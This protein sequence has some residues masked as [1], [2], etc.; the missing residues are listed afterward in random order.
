MN[1]ETLQLLKGSGYDTSKIPQQLSP[2]QP[3]QQE[4]SQGLRSFDDPAFVDELVSA[5]SPE[6]AEERWKKH[7]GADEVFASVDREILAMKAANP[8]L[9]GN[10]FTSIAESRKAELRAQAPGLGA[11]EQAKQKLNTRMEA[12]KGT[13]SKFN[14]EQWAH[15]ADL[16][17]KGVPPFEA[18][19]ETVSKVPFT[20]GESADPLKGYIGGG[21][22]GGSGG[23]NSAQSD[24]NNADSYIYDAA[25]MEAIK[26]KFD[27]TPELLLNYTRLLAEDYSAGSSIPTNIDTPE[28]QAMADEA[29]GKVEKSK[30]GIDLFKKIGGRVIEPG[31]EVEEIRAAKTS[32]KPLLVLSPDGKAYVEQVANET[33][34]TRITTY[35]KTAKEN[36]EKKAK[37]TEKTNSGG[38]WDVTKRTVFG[39]TEEQ[40]KADMEIAGRNLESSDVLERAKAIEEVAQLKN[41]LEKEKTK[42]SPLYLGGSEKKM[43][44]YQ[45]VQKAQDQATG[46][47]FGLVLGVFFLLLVRPKGKSK[48]PKEVAFRLMA[49]GLILVIAM[50]TSRFW[51]K[52]DFVAFID[53]I[54]RTSINA[55]LLWV[56]GYGFGWVKFYLI[57]RKNDGP[58]GAVLTREG[59]SVAS[60]SANQGDPQA[61]YQLALCYF[62]GQG[63]VKN[64]I[65]AYK[66][67]LLAQANG[68]PEA[69]RLC[70]QIE[71]KL[72]NEE[73]LKGQARASEFVSEKAPESGTNEIT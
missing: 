71:K 20:S 28:A 13:Q 9:P 17:G 23:D 55:G 63:V 14:G 51:V 4:Q 48:S 10:L 35:L 69:R 57:R 3:V 22:S 31:A 21:K 46:F 38:F 11:L 5:G 44:Q 41:L 32:G 40:I 16:I 26:K 15:Y 30:T 67:V 58:S 43:D 53:A 6:A 73:I 45:L 47:L 62:H 29:R 42:N 2:V 70:S 56:I 7:T 27:Q 49:W 54:L 25:K 36:L 18:T 8:K 59:F 50:E 1:E 24:Y 19:Q 37:E 65:E 61:Q 72:S 68:I 66:W 39:P 64:T 12:A 34:V 52:G 33:D 60:S